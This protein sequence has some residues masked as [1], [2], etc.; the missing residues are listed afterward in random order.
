MLE[1]RDI[2]LSDRER[3]QRALTASDFMGCEY[4]FANNLAWR[5]LADSKISI[6]TD[7]YQT[8]DS[9]FNGTIFDKSEGAIDTAY[10]Y[11]SSKIS[12]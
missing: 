5:R 2:T 1:F 10:S 12:K 7:A 8:N 3:V 11:L 6:G 9:V 4:S